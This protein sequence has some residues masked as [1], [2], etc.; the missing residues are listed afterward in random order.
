M[1]FVVCY[2]GC[3]ASSSLMEK[4]YDRN[5]HK[6][7]SQEITYHQSLSEEFCDQN[8]D[9]DKGVFQPTPGKVRKLGGGVDHD[10]RKGE[11]RSIT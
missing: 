9:I 6:R 11:C 4:D 7:K 8:F 5:K 3:H 2:D 1:P 10:A